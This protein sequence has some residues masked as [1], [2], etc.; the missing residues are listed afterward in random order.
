MTRRHLHDRS[1]PSK[2]GNRKPSRS[3]ARGIDINRI[4]DAAADADCANDSRSHIDLTLT[5]WTLM[6]DGCETLTGWMTRKVVT[7]DNLVRSN[8]SFHYRSLR[9]ISYVSH[10]LLLWFISSMFFLIHLTD[11]NASL[12]S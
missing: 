3:L 4:S 2:L 10:V 12:Q 11:R 8:V 9:L 6:L 5:T 7:S 1:A